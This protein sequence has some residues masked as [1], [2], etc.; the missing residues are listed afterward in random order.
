MKYARDSEIYR[1]SNRLK[2]KLL[3]IASNPIYSAIFA[4]SLPIFTIGTS[5]INLVT[6]NSNDDLVSS[7][8]QFPGWFSRTTMTSH[9]R[10]S[11]PRADG[12]L[13]RSDMNETNPT[14][15]MDADLRLLIIQST[16]FCNID[17]SYCYLPS[18]TNT[19]RISS[20][21]LEEVRRFIVPVKKHDSTLPV[22]WHAGEPLVVDQAFYKNAFQ[23][24]G[25]LGHQPG[26]RHNFQTNGTLINE[27]WCEFFAEHN[28]QIG[29]SIDG[30][31]RVHDANRKTRSGQGTFDKTVKALLL[32]K[33]FKIP[34]STISVITPALL[35]AIDESVDFFSQLGVNSIAFNIEEA[36]GAHASSSL[37]ENDYRS[38]IAN[39]FTRLADLQVIQPRLRIRELDAM[40]ANF[41]AP[42]GSSTERSTNRPG[43]IINIDASGGISTF[44]PELLGQRSLRYGDF[45]WGN[46]NTNTWSEVKDHASFRLAAKDIASGISR[47][48]NTC[49]YYALCGG[50]DPS[51]KLAEHGNFDVAETVSCR[52]HLQTVADVV[53]ADFDR[54]MT[55]N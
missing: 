33:E 21:T 1:S 32:L 22:V 7:D 4:I 11:G 48:K 35:D 43:G 28:I 17:C 19:R 3:W 5:L 31:Q 44:S 38:A 55:P 20:K 14:E 54:T 50:G 6:L 41:T 52:L 10:T 49:G 24:L 53:L 23:I 51:N 12:A 42:P 2:D 34:F 26:V 9:D 15:F 36:E 8:C 37:F 27:H 29:L 25:D 46:V 47:C 18:R 39:L 45:S 30:P 40:R 13:L 16:P